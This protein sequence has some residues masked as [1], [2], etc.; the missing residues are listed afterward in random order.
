MKNTHNR[1]KYVFLSYGIG[2]VGGGQNYLKNR[3]ELYKT[4]NMNVYLAYSLY[5][6]QNNKWL[7]D[8]VLH[9]P[10]IGQPIHMFGA[11]YIN[12]V[13]KKLQQ[14]IAYEEGDSIIIESNN[15]YMAIW[16]ELLAQACKGKHF[17]YILGENDLITNN[18]ES[19]YFVFKLERK[20]IA[21]IHPDSIKKFFANYRLIENSK[22]FCVP[23]T[24]QI[25]IR[26]YSVNE[27]NHLPHSDY[28]IGLLSRLD[29]PYVLPTLNDLIDFF[30]I[31][32]DL[33]FNLIV[34]GE[35]NKIIMRQI[36]G[37]YQNVNN[38]NLILTGAFDPLPSQYLE[39]CN[40]C[41]GT[42][43]CALLT[44]KYGRITVTIDGD[45]YKPIGILG[46]TTDNR[47]FRTTEP[48]IHIKEILEQILF[49]KVYPLRHEPILEERPREESHRMHHE[50][51]M[52][53]ASAKEYYD[54][55]STINKWGT[56]RGFIFISKRFI[57][58]LFGSRIYY[59]LAG[60]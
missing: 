35:G 12:R 28:T 23:A 30:D 39:L 14:F 60:K 1:K 19:N 2:G 7:F 27:L 10:V 42:S 20:E 5:N 17:Y 24:A 43:G 37:M 11:R 54:V 25:G 9:L 36:E 26:D 46:H 59:K 38:V 45:D 57:E 51:I 4:Q 52:S 33:R 6:P 55:D 21:G 16:A 31:H 29:K 41:I 40:V 49:D 58:S 8:E 48:I 3:C 44:H 32:K 13:I 34:V 15:Q 18:F 53:S 56:K 47:L 22:Q 50:Y